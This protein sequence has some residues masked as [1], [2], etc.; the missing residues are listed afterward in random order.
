MNDKDK[1]P[2]KPVIN[3][4]NHNSFKE[5]TSFISYLK[6]YFSNLFNTNQ[7][8]STSKTNLKNCLK[9]SNILADISN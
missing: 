5:N 9:I 3:I 6:V 8:N 7:G 4:P 1:Q 2:G